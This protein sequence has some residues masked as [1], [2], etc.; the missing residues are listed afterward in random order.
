MWS[1]VTGFSPLQG[2]LMLERVSTLRSF[3]LLCR[4]LLYGY[5]TFYL[6]SQPFLDIWVVSTFPLFWITLVW[7]YK[8]L[9]RPMF[10][11]VL[12]HHMILSFSFIICIFQFFCNKHCSAQLKRL[13]GSPAQVSVS[14]NYLSS[15]SMKQKSRLIG[16]SFTS[17]GIHR[18]ALWLGFG[19]L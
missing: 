6:P 17:G 3:L 8:L 13:K 10:S 1:F 14:I 5:A 12:D 19:G 7:T 9:G 2:S 4:V 11:F 18:R 16:S 15:V